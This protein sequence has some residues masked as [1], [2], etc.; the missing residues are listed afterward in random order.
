MFKNDLQAVLLAAGRGSR[1][2][3]LGS[4]SAKC[5]LLIGNKPMIWY[6]INMLHKAKYYGR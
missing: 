4:N 5:L 6:P 2:T 1:L 3:E